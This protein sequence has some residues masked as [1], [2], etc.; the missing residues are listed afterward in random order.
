MLHTNPPVNHAQLKAARSKGR[1]GIA[2][3][4]VDSLRLLLF[5]QPKTQGA[6]RVSLTRK[7]TLAGLLG[8]YNNVPD[9]KGLYMRNSLAECHTK[10]HHAFLFIFN[11]SLVSL[12]LLAISAHS[13]R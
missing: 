10:P 4:R 9:H 11:H 5:L 6:L 2:F 13:S 3:D 7:P 12:N 1:C 8:R